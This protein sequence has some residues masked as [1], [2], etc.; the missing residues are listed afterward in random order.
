MINGVKNKQTTGYNG[1]DK[2]NFFLDFLLMNNYYARRGYK[3]ARMV[4]LIP[5]H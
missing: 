2:G 1:Y 3:G 4:N 5:K